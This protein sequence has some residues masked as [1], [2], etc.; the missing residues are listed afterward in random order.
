MVKSKETINKEE[1]IGHRLV[2]QH[3]LLSDE[4]A[5]EILKKY[6]ITR[7][8]LPKIKKKDPAFAI[9]DIKPKEGDIILIK[10]VEETASYDYYRLVI[11]K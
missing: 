10:R 1:S 8:Q 9:F 3:I 6:N 2:P 7:D 5:E 11:N 4:E